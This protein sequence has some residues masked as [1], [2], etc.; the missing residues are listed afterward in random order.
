MKAI[1]KDA[2]NYKS[3]FLLILQFITETQLNHLTLL[4]QE[5]EIMLKTILKLLLYHSKKY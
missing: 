1:S 2:M 4:F 5:F 3:S